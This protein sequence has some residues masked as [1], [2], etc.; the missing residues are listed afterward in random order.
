MSNNYDEPKYIHVKR[1]GKINL[2][3]KEEAIKNLKL[4]CST[5]DFGVLAT[6][7][8]DDCYSSLISFVISQNYSQLVFATPKDTK[9][10]KNISSNSNI[11]ILIDNH[12]ENPKNINN[13]VATTL[14][15]QAK[16]LDQAYKDKWA[17]VLLEKHPYLKGFIKSKNTV[18]ILVNI[19]QYH[20][21]S[22][23]QEVIEWS[24]L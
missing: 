2:D 4:L 1:T 3:R 13:I 12:N 14:I 5:Q 21:V 16:I 6:R 15:G 10:L 18:L 11:S 24:P 20:Y 17:P 22:S 23:F 19:S 8:N 7:G 9:K